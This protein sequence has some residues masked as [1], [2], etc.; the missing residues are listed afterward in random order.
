MAKTDKSV[1]DQTLIGHTATAFQKPVS[2]DTS[3][4]ADNPLSK[5]GARGEVPNTG[6]EVNSG[7]AGPDSEWFRA[8]LLERRNTPF[9]LSPSYRDWGINE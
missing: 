7:G 2:P 6:P 1:G 9:A 8:M 5:L 3:E 4:D